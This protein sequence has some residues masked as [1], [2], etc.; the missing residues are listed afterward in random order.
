MGN[1]N[2]FIGVVFTILM[3]E[4]NKMCAQSKLPNEDQDPQCIVPQSKLVPDY[5]HEKQK[6]IT[7]QAD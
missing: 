2:S 3:Q 1:L 6:K 5:G 7:Q 4:T